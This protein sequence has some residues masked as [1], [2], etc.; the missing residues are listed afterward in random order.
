MNSKIIPHNSKNGVHLIPIS[1]YPS[2]DHI[3]YGKVKRN[4]IKGRDD[5]IENVYLIWD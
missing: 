5:W 4:I 2:L 3:L 1:V